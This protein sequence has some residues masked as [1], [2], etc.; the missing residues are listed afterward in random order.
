MTQDDHKSEVR[1]ISLYLYDCAL[2]IDYI[3]ACTVRSN[4]QK[5]DH[6]E[7]DLETFVFIIS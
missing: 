4:G 1:C 6:R 3:K 7:K 5:I 2:E